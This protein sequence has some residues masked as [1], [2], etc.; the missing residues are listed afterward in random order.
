MIS[1][2]IDVSKRKSMAVIDARIEV[3]QVKIRA[4]V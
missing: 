3:T 4:C 1:V 2:G